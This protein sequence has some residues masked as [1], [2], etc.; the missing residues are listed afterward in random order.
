[1]ESAAS[2]VAVVHASQGKSSSEGSEPTTGIP[3]E[4]PLTPPQDN[5]VPVNPSHKVTKTAHHTHF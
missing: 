3:T 5:Q 4:E 2:P 1:M